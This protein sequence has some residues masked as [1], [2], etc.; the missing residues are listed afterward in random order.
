MVTLIIKRGSD[1]GKHIEISSFPLS[2]GA[3]VGNS[4]EIA[5]PDM[6]A[7]HF[8]IKKRGKLYILENKDVKRRLYLNGDRVINSVLKNQDKILAGNT[9]IM[10]IKPTETIQIAKELGQFD[11]LIDQISELTTTAIPIDQISLPHFEEIPIFHSNIIN[12]IFKKTA[13]LKQI[14][15]SQSNIL[16]ASSMEEASACLLKEIHAYYPDLSRACHFIC[17]KPATQFLPTAS[18][19][20]KKETKPFQISELALAEVVNRKKGVFL[21][22]SHPLVPNYRIVLPMIANQEVISIVHLEIDHAPNKLHLASLEKILTLMYRASATFETML[23]R[24]ELDTFMLGMV[25][26]VIATIEAKDTYT[27]GHSE[28]VCKFSMAIADELRLDHETKKMLMISSLCHDIGKIAVPDAILKKASRLDPEEYEEM[29]LHPVIGSNIIMNVP[30]A[31]KFLSGV[32]YH[33]EKWDGTGYPEGLE[34][35]NIP[36]FGRI[37][38]VADVFDA[39]ISGRSYSGFLDESDAID[40]LQK[41]RELFDPQ[42][43]DALVNAWSNGA[44][45]HRTSTKSNKKPV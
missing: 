14:Y 32:K 1:E 20:F 11:I 36:F 2:V 28:R 18:K 38:A 45:T 22:S 31:K 9:E 29:K 23:L 3:A 41:E 10:F 7:V 17:P 40:K 34:G 30:G 25:E 42:I 21:R 24:R 16:A 15:D 12:K 4:L 44:I 37:V 39:M 33:H 6:A 19:Q 43:L 35:E 27:V 5:D 26:T 8:L 13:N